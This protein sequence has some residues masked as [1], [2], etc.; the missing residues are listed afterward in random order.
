MDNGTY[1]DK[2]LV[3]MG[4]EAYIKVVTAGLERTFGWTND[5]REFLKTIQL[6]TPYYMVN[7]EDL[8]PAQIGELSNII[9]KLQR[10]QN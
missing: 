4:R 2:Q 7:K 1:T 5:Y 8:T 6:Y 10:K 3:S 9:F